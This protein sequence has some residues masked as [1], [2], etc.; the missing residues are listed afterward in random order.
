MKFTDYLDSYN[1]R[2]RLYP[3]FLTI[4]P[5][6]AVIAIRTRWF[7]VEFRDFIWLVPLRGYLKI[8]GHRGQE[9]HD[10]AKREYVQSLSWFHLIG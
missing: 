6:I 3:A 10:E 1:W 8:T 5:P 2:A 7:Q 4:L 9:S